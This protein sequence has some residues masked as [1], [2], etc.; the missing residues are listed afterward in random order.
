MLFRSRGPA[1]VQL[2]RALCVVAAGDPSE[3]ARHTIH[4]LETLPPHCRD[5]AVIRRT[6]ALVLGV[7]PERARTLPSVAEAREL[8][9]LPPGQS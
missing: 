1:Q 7:V 3:G 4:K 5:N 9:A 6:A 8:L 2:H